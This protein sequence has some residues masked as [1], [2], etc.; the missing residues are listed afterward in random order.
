MADFGA[1]TL[2]RN[3]GFETLLGRSKGLL[4]V[5]D[6]A[7][8]AAPTSSTVLI[9]GDTGTG[10]ELLAR[11]MHALSAGRTKPFVTINCGAYPKTCWNPSS[12]GNVR[13]SFTGA[14]MDRKGQ[15]EAANGG[16]LF[17]DEIGEMPPELQVKLLRLAG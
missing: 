8:R 3:P 6:K 9:Q 10:K 13:G 11:A 2:T 7:A 4:A 14:V 15:V 17:L 1:R 5:L 16:T 12:S